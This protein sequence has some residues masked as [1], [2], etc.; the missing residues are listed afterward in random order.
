MLAKKKPTIKEP[1]GALASVAQGATAL[2]GAGA[3]LLVGG[4]V[5]CLFLLLAALVLIPFGL[6]PLASVEQEP[7]ALYAFALSALPAGS[8]VPEVA[9]AAGPMLAPQLTVLSLLFA[10]PPQ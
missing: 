6:I 8:A 7:G 10:V 5:L 2:V 1:E 9:T 3:L 4:I